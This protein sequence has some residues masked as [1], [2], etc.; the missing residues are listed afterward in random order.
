MPVSLLPG[1][2]AGAGDQE[3]DQQNPPPSRRTP[4]G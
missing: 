1:K 2:R 4:E 3:H